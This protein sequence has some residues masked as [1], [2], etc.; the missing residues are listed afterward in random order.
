MPI[1]PEELK[2]RIAKINRENCTKAER[3]EINRLGKKYLPKLEK[4]EKHLKTMGNR[5][6]YS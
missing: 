5:N 4:Y 1:K 3:K 2:K 6:S